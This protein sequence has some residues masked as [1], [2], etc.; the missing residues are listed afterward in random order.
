MAVALSWLVLLECRLAG[1]RCSV[2][3][4]TAVKLSAWGFLLALIPSGL[5]R[6]FM[7]GAIPVVCQVRAMLG[8]WSRFLLRD[9][10]L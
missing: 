9:A 8:R 5:G 7:P 1:R 3:F 2:A 6:I 4:W 10:N